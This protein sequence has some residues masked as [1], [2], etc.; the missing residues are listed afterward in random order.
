MH[1]ETEKLIELAVANGEI[2]EKERHVILKKANEMGDDLD[3]V[4][5]V[6]EGRL[7]Q[8]QGAGPVIQKEQVGKIKVCPS[9]G[10]SVQALNIACSF[11]GHE[12][13]GVNAN[14]SVHLLLDKIARLKVG[15]GQNSSV[16]LDLEISRLIN[17][18][19]IPTTKE[20][21]LEFLSVCSAQA[22]VDFMARGTG[23]AVAAWANKGN[24]AL[25]K[26]KIVFIED[27]KT[28]SLLVEFERKLKSS[29]KKSRMVWL[30]IF[31]PLFLLLLVY[32]ITRK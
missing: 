11:C 17:S 7:H 9:C 20:D 16:D 19:S 12:F 26:A 5:M 32:L 2:T 30:M 27:V 6:L 13:V 14:A 25:L 1:P 22:D 24:E 8:L 10:G 29:A 4:E 18:T 21:L 23:Y 15:Y 3:E 28:L 31:V